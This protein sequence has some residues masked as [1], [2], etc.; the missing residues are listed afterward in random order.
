MREEQS[1]VDN[2]NIGE[3]VALDN[4]QKIMLIM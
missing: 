1:L 4:V 3:A 2:G